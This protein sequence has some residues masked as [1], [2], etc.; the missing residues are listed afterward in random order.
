MIWTDK[1]NHL[2]PS[3]GGAGLVEQ[4]SLPASIDGGPVTD[5]AFNVY[6]GKGGAGTELTTFALV[7]P[8]ASGSVS[9]DL[10]AV[11][12]DLALPKIAAADGVSGAA[13]AADY[14]DSIQLGTEFGPGTGT[15]SFIW[16]LSAL[17]IDG[18]PIIGPPTAAL[19]LKG[20]S[21]SDGTLEVAAQD[22]L[23]LKNGKITVNLLTVDPGA[24]IA[25]KGGAARQLYRDPVIDNGGLIEATGG[26]LLLKNAQVN[27][28]AGA[29]IY[30]GPG[31][32]VS[33]A[34]AVIENGTLAT[35]PTG[36]IETT[37]ANS[38]FDNLTN[39][40]AV[41]VN[42]STALTLMGT[43]DNAGTI[44]LDA[45]GG[46]KLNIDGD[47]VLSGGGAVEMTELVG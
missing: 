47:V 8:I 6:V 12:A 23:K 21:F 34:S 28:A 35:D 22:K 27:N 2:M 37:D 5:T 24:T 42:D 1:E 26:D 38:V 43:I 15:E 41:I 30:A 17:S 44:A 16:N 40:G 9:V 4:V 36:A 19:A 46:A 10:S 31:A 13:I 11:L 45:V 29:E 33:L 14:L 25:A 32:I 20:D 3:G 7:D 39:T 18:A